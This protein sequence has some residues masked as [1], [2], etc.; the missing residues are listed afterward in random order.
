[1]SKRLVNSDL[2][3]CA[4]ASDLGWDESDVE[5]YLLWSEGMD[6]GAEYKEEGE[7][8]EVEDEDEGRP[9]PVSRSIGHE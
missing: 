7:P 8:R 4:F 5:E 2:T 1:M 6:P 9:R 3:R